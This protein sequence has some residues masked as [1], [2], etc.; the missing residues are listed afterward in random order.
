[1]PAEEVKNVGARVRRFRKLRGWS[2]AKLAEASGLT[3]EA[4]GRLERGEQTPRLDTLFG[5]AGG[6][7]VEPAALL[8]DEVAGPRPARDLEA[9]IEPLLDQPAHVR[10]LAARLVR[11]LIEEG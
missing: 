10:R 6:L 3:T 2:M 9:V 11:A 1:M 7:E 4:L 5:I 8:S